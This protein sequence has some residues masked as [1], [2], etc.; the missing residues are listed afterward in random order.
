MQGGTL[1]SRAWA[2]EPTFSQQPSAM[3]GF[4]RIK[5][6]NKIREIDKRGPFGDEK[7]LQSVIIK[8]DVNTNTSAADKHFWNKLLV[9][10]SQFLTMSDK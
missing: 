1:S 3:A 5:T 7:K 10:K 8:T 4:A 9:L 2:L 6:K